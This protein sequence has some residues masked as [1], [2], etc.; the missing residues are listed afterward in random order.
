MIPW[1]LLQFHC[2]KNWNHSPNA[3]GLMAGWLGGRQADKIL[4]SLKLYT[5]VATRL[6]IQPFTVYD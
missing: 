4:L 5:G 6:N 2:E 1:I 3:T